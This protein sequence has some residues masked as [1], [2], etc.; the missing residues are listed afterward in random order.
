MIELTQERDKRRF[1]RKNFS[2]A[3]RAELEAEKQRLELGVVTQ[4]RRPLI[5]KIYRLP[6]NGQ[7]Y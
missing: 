3:K 2:L 5:D 4:I 1:A 7:R 6:L